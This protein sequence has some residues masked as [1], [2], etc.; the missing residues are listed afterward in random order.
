MEKLKVAIYD[1]NAE[2][3]RRLMNYLNSKYGESMDVISFTKKEQLLRE[4]SGQRFDFVVTDDISETGMTPAI[5]ICDE[6]GQDG[7]YRYGSAKVLAKKILEQLEKGMD[8]KV[9][10]GEM[11]AV[12]S[13][14]GGVG[15]TKYAL[16]KAEELDGIYVGMEDFCSIQTDDYWMEQ[17]LF[18]IKEREENICRRIEEHLQWSDGAKVIPSARCFLDYRYMDKEDYHWFLDKLREEEK[19]TFVFDIGVGSLSDFEILSLFDRVMLITSEEETR[20][21]KIALFLDLIKQM[22]P[23]IRN[24][25][26]FVSGGQRV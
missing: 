24:K 8:H 23:E 12:Y 25:I 5:R 22:E 3:S 9:K 4:L 20:R 6:D 14:A 26:T 13:P 17:M 15:K 2:Y 19:Q 21:Q 11:L 7:F 10:K 18:L 1:Q 16:N